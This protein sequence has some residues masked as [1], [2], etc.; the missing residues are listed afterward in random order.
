MSDSCLVLIWFVCFM[1]GDR[2][3]LIGLVLGLV[4]W[5]LYTGLCSWCCFWFL[6]CGVYVIVA[7]L[8]FVG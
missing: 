4:G 5:F 2:A 6:Y 1:F 8:G 7:A 3:R